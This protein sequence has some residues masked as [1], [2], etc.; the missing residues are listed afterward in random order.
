M[1]VRKPVRNPVARFQKQFFTFLG[2]KC[3]SK[4]FLLHHKLVK[5]QLVAISGMHKSD[6]KVSNNSNEEKVD[7][8]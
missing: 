7:T 6:T 5:Y 1:Y 8:R 4:K 2:S 3:D